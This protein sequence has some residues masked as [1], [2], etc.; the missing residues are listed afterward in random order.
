L[1]K[2]IVMGLDSTQRFTDRV[3]DYVRY[4]PNY[5]AEL[6][7]ALEQHAGLTSAS[8]VA[9]IGAGTGIS[10]ELLL[11]SACTVW[12]VEPNDAMRQAAVAW[13]GERPG[14][15]TTAGTAEATDLPDQSIDLVAAG[16]AAH[17]FNAPA[18][19]SEFLRIT[20]PPHR[21]ALFWN[22]RRSDDSPF[23]AAYE[24]LL[25]RYGTDYAQI[26]HDGRE[27]RLA[28]E[29]SSV[30]WQHFEFPNAQSLD[31]DGLR[32]RLL[33]SSYVPAAEAP[34][35]GPMLADLQ[36]LFDNYAENGT[37]T[38]CYRTELYLGTLTPGSSAS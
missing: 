34:K 33:S 24:E 28:L 16:Q 1:Q 18:A 11:R 7:A 5:P 19:R 6:L 30:P 8:I 12:A 29:L 2:A 37:V 9:D 20:R 32:G 23:S 31:F 17:W 4:R 15:H 13:L 10:S 22:A 14:F 21:V 27:Q 26:R 38:M 25:E 3:A 35:R 36:R